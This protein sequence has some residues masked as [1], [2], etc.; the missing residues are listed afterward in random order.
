MISRTCKSLGLRLELGRKL[1]RYTCNTRLRRRI[2]VSLMVQRKTGHNLFFLRP[3]SRMFF[4]ASWTSVT[5]TKQRQASF[6]RC[7]R[8]T[9]RPAML[10]SFECV[11]ADLT[12]DIICRTRIIDE[13]NCIRNS[14]IYSGKDEM[15]YGVRFCL[16]KFG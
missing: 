1:P 12:G 11:A 7:P 9:K 4:P 14:E 3:S 6:F 2:R 13:D 8:S 5:R 16:A 15:F 10:A